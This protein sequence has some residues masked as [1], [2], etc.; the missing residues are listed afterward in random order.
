MI[1]RL[2]NSINWQCDQITLCPLRLNFRQLMF[3]AKLPPLLLLFGHR[4]CISF[5]VS[6]ADIFAIAKH[7]LY[8]PMNTYA[9]L[10]L[11]L[12]LSSVQGMHNTQRMFFFEASNLVFRQTPWLAHFRKVYVFTFLFG[13]L[14]SHI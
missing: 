2:I 8:L 5:F 12:T 10:H 3:F 4:F 7:T 9:S 13:S 1:F 6:L 11:T 14:T